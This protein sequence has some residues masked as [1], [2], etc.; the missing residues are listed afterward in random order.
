M[1]MLYLQRMLDNEGVPVKCYAVH[2]GLVPTDLWYDGAGKFLGMVA[3][4]AKR[5]FRVLNLI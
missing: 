5:I 3:H 2:P 4:S 1:S